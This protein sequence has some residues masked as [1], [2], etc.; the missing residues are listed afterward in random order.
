MVTSRTPCVQP[1]VVAPEEMHP[2]TDIL[3]YPVSLALNPGTLLFLLVCTFI[4]LTPSIDLIPVIGRYDEK[5]LLEC[6][7]L[8]FAGF[9]L[10][11]LPAVRDDWI[12]LANQL[13]LTHRRLLACLITLGLLSALLATAPGRALLDVSLYLLLFIACLH[14]AIQRHHLGH[15]FDKI[16]AYALLLT[17]AFSLTSF[18]A[19]YTAANIEPVPLLH[20]D[21]FGNFSHIRFFSQFQSWTLP[22]IVL[23]LLLSSRPA[24]IR[25]WLPLL[26]AGGWWFLLFASGTRGTLL[27]LIVAGV[28]TAFAYGRRALPWFK[29]Q[30]LALLIGLTCYAL[31]ILLPPLLTVADT[32]AIQDGT[33]GRSLT[34]SSGRFHLWQVAGSM[35]AQHPLLGVGP[36]HYACGVT[37]GIAAHPHNAVLQIAAEW[38]LPAALIVIYLVF[39]G[40]QA[41]IRLGRTRLQATPTTVAAGFG[42]DQGTP[43]AMLFPA[44]L[45]SLT[46]AATHALF[47]GVINMPLSQVSMVLVIGWMLGLYFTS[48]PAP[49]STPTTTKDRA[50]WMTVI[51][52]ACIGLLAGIVPDLMNFGELLNNAH[53]P[54]GATLFMPRFWQ[55]GLICGG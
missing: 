11:L 28:I 43:H 12:R 51:L 16:V 24:G 39:S 6:L 37:N 2:K 32:S 17:S 7:L 41:W 55:Q 22:L 45:A 53:V 54:P 30:G 48:A 49:A 52:A 44:L 18:A 42:Q 33:L 1:T 40:I 19:A 9:S 21:L 13:P 10:I 31:L 20:W 4:V 3:R 27:G 47:S 36:M 14:L 29:W 23:P 50:I 5:R 25:L 15:H 38:G 8:L 26:L 35:I 46:T 34:H